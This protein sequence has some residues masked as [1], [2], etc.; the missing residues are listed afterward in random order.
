[1]SNNV[2]ERYDIEKKAGIVADGLCVECF[3]EV[4]SKHCNDPDAGKREM[5]YIESHSEE[6]MYKSEGEHPNHNDGCNW[7]KRI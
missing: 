2:P 6:F 3:D 7:P 4:I 1:M 5:E